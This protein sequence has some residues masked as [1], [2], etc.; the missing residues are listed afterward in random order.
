MAGSASIPLSHEEVPQQKNASAKETK[1][2]SE[3]GWPEG[4]TSC[5]LV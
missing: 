2:S 1:K 3:G 5:L 4:G